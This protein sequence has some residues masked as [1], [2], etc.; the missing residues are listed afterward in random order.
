MN[1]TAERLYQLLPAIYRIRDAEQG[2]PLKTLIAV[3]AEQAE[4]I[5]GDITRL[6]ENWFIETCQEWVVP[7]M[8]DL[9]GVRGLH[10]VGTAAV[11]SRRA[12]VANTL[13]YRRRKGT[14]TVLEQLALDTTG[15]RVRAVEFFELLGTTQHYNHIRLYNHRTPDLRHTNEL[16]LLNTAFDTIAHTADVRHITNDRGRHNIPNVGLFLWRLQ[17]YPVTRG[18]AR[19]AAGA[20]AGRFTFNP[21]GYDVP[22]F[23]RP[24]TEKEI[25]HLAEEVNV[26]GLLRRRPLYDELEARRQAVVDDRTPKYIYFDDRPVLE[27]FL[28]GGSTPLSPDEILICNLKYWHIPSDK[29][30]YKHVDSN[31]NI[32]SVDKPIK[33]AVDPLLG[34]LTFP[35]AVAVTV[36]KVQSSYAYGFSGDVGGGPYNRQESVLET[37]SREVT[38]QRGVS[39]EIAP[40]PDE[41]FSTVT[42]AVEAWNKQPEGTV[43][44]IAVMDSSTFKETLTGPK[45]IKIPKGSRLIIIAADWPEVELPGGLKHRIPGQ[46]EAD[47]LRPHLKGHINVQGTA[48]DSSLTGGDLVLDGLLIEGKLSV[49]AGNLGSLRVA[50]STLSPD[51]GGLEVDSKNER[52]KISLIRTIC[53]PVKLKAAV[54]KLFVKESIVDNGDKEAVAANRTAVDLQKC[55][56]FGT[57][58]V[59][60]IEA[61]N[62]IFTGKVE[63]VRSQEGCLRFSYVPPDSHTP[64]QYRCQPNLEISTQISNEKKKSST[65]L[66]QT[67]IN[68]VTKSVQEWLVPGFTSTEY[69]HHAYGQ[70]S[71]TC[72]SLIMTGAEDSSEMG[73]FSILVQPQ[74][75]ANLQ[76]SLDEYMRFGLEAGIIYVT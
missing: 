10:S 61:G 17:S 50:H 44:V 13:S 54:S 46:L 51:Q 76:T 72:P 40:V 27:I 38:W 16:E 12:R 31:G 26:P 63:A 66:S 24:R 45:Q 70:L 34:R 69:W 47:E 57:V 20:P 23:N 25:T 73:V 1:F 71:R 19:P 33:V 22:L 65:E 64:R 3:I 68:A 37:L 8:G 6:Y 59:L 52:L 58:N 42:Q 30:T 11:F 7:Y 28:N 74:R 21:L 56:V 53:G 43:G 9:L 5:E 35:A 62:C 55:T 67:A 75:A 60:R 15:W 29:K 14:A 32:V 48:A 4:V 36:D 2:E 41:I 49:L 39:K 18:T